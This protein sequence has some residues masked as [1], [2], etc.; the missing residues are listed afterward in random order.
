MHSL[1]LNIWRP[2]LEI[3]L[4]WVTIYHILLFFE[5]TRALQVL[6]G[7]VILLFV[8][9]LAQ[10]LELTVIEWLM[11]KFGISVITAVLIIFHPEIRHG[12]AKLGQHKLFKPVLA[13][14]E[15]DRML[16]EISKGT[17]TMCRE[18][19]GALIAIERKDHL[20][21]YIESGVAID[22]VVSG[23]LLQS[24]FTHASILHDGAVI[25][26]NGRIAAAGC[27]F[28]LTDN[29]DLSRMFGMRHRAA[30]G[31]S[32]QTDA[33]IIVVSEE[34]HDISLVYQSRM[35][36]DLNKDELVVKIKELLKTEN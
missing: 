1:L 34:R 31:L 35:F 8:F 12:L 25:I 22:S 18:K 10:R 9:F 14:E 24:I 20:N 7:I 5:G 21:N 3:T 11:S 26:Q 17:E 29:P 23:D 36:K 27:I 4:L 19:I 2:V 6:R 30:L 15:L 33:L 16:L 28:P 32:E 13:G